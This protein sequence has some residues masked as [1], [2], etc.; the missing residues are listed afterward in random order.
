MGRNKAARRNE[1]EDENE[2]VIGRLGWTS[3]NC[4]Y[5]RRGGKEAELGALSNC[6]SGS[7]DR[8]VSAVV[9]RAYNM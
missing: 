8:R 7:P 5:R 6:D 9:D 1:S 3:G 2:T 4:S